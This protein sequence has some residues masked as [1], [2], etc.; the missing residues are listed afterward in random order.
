MKTPTA[1]AE[2]LINYMDEAAN[3]L[4]LLSAQ[5]KEGVSLYLEREKRQLEVLKSRIPSLVVKRL[6][7]ARMKL[8]IAQKDINRSAQACLSSQRHRLELISQRIH[9]ASPQRI[10]AKGYSI[11]LINGKAITNQSQVKTGDEIT[12]QLMNGEIKIGRASCRERV[13][14]LV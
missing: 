3:R 2:L 7:D 12:T 13:Y 9:D 8:L 5:L 14:V 10:L 11:T 1:A 6:S 4:Y